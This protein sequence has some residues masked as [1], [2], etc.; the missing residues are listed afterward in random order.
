MP[1]HS[2]LAT[3]RGDTLPTASPWP[4]RIQQCF[5]QNGSEVRNRIRWRVE[6]GVPMRGNTWRDRLVDIRD[7]ERSGGSEIHTFR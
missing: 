1:S 2:G 7:K 3:H 5:N 4:W 6:A